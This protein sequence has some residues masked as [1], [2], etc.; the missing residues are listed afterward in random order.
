VAEAKIEIILS[1]GAKA[2]E[3]LKELGKQANTLNKEIKD[4]KPGTAE[5]AAKAKDLQAVSGQMDNIKKQ[6]KGTTDASNALKSS[7]GGVL[8]Q[9]PG[10]SQ[11]SSVMQSAKG[12]VG[13]LTSGF[14]LLK[15]AIIAT[16]I[17]ALILAVTAVVGWF[18]KT[19]KG[20]N[21]LS[22]AF[23]AMGAIIDTLMNRLWNIGDTLKQLFSDPIQFFKDLGKDIKQAAV[24]G[25]DLVQVFDDIED[26]QRDLDVQAKQQENQIDQLLLQSKN[27][28][29]SYKERIALL[30]AADKITRKSY[31]DQL[32]L[33]KEYLAAVEREV[34]AAT[35]QGTMGDELADKLRDAKLKVL[36]LEG[37]Q[38]SIEEKIQNRRDQIIGKQENANQKLAVDKEKQNAK[39][40]KD[41]EAAAAEKLRLEEEY[42]AAIRFLEDSRIATMQD[43]RAKDLEKLKIDLA[44]QIEAIDLNAPFYA[45]RVAA[46]VELGRKQANDIIKKWDDKE[47]A[48]RKA[49]GDEEIATLKAI[50]DQA[51]AIEKQKQ[52]NIQAAMVG[53]L[54][55][56]G[57]F[58]GAL[59]S[60][61]E[62][63]S[64]Q[65]KEYAI[66]QAVISSIEGA[67]NA[68]TST[69]K[70]PYVG[71]ALAPV[72]AATALLAGYAKVEQIR[73]TKV[74]PMNKPKA[75]KGGRLV[76]ARHSAGGIDLEAEDGEYIINRAS[77]M[78]IGYDRLDALN[79]FKY[80]MGG[81]V[82]PAGMASS[83]ARSSAANGG[84][85]AAFP[86]FNSLLVE[87]RVL[88]NKIDTWATSLKVNNNLQEVD[89]GLKTLQKLKTDADV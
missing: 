72:A 62:S 33:S 73:N 52:A 15:G 43:G 69:A 50:A 18:S 17:G 57:N 84:V 8:N 3:T 16:G 36:D 88:S 5:F 32:N 22:G 75:E 38:I 56:A 44:R 2:G 83:A 24:E 71:T 79:R 34:A 61:Q 45:A 78:A 39:D 64:K 14:G 23:K 86:E 37:Q 4:L 60:M 41:A 29:T 46:V 81:P 77:A 10:F 6:V 40:L 58:F 68:Y 66:A 1:N 21:M 47:A 53:G 55:V 87:F 67:I 9:I 28:A 25:Y 11:I 48:D 51:V 30:D 59:A 80:A 13:G 49:R 26:R 31:T 76:G 63:G 54:Q 89:K 19:E 12:G 65:A 35:K 74:P 85:S 70:I 20:A 7:F 42:I 82:T 27:V